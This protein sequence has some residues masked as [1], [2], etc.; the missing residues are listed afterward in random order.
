MGNEII[1]ISDIEVQ[2]HKFHQ[3]KSPISIHDVNIGRIVI[4]NK[5]PFGKNRF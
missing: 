3:H 4:P 2:K 1:R 5:F